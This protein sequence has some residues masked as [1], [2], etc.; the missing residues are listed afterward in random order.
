MVPFVALGV[1]VAATLLG[2][3]VRGPVSAELG[4]LHIA[5]HVDVP[6]GGFVAAAYVIATCIPLLLS[7]YQHVN[8]FGALNLCAGI[9][10]AYTIPA[11]FASLWCVWAAVSSGAIA[12]HLR[13][14][15][16]RAVGDAH[17][18]SLRQASP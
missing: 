4:E 8:V 6:G 14:T 11:G 15:Q 17:H 1:V 16:Q 3:M 12:A 10:L 2:A 5:Y 13:Y 9:A 18:P 7:S